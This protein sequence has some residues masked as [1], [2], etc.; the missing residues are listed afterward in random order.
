M[1]RGV[2]RGRA[3]WGCV[4]DD[5][6]VLGEVVPQCAVEMQYYRAEGEWV[7]LGEGVSQYVLKVQY[8]HVDDEWVGLTEVLQEAV[9]VQYYHVDGDDQTVA[10]EVKVVHIDP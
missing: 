4:D 3:G 6:I 1:E 8:C 7:E 2:E 5:M 10:L 9:E